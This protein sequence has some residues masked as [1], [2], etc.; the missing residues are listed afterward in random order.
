MVPALPAFKEIRNIL[1]D[2]EI[3]PVE[4]CYDIAGHIQTLY[5]ELP[6]HLNQNE[7]EILGHALNT[8]FAK[9]DTKR[10]VDYS[11]GIII[12]TTYCRGKFAVFHDF[13]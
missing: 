6:Y 9:K 3:L 11:K 8:S 5:T 2:Y 13:Y 1:P 10:S 7:K 4:P 12:V